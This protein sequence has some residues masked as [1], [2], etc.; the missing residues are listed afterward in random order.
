MKKS[1]S[2]IFIAS[3][4]LVSCGGKETIIKEVLVTT[5]QVATTDAPV[6]SPSNKYDEYLY[7]LREFSGQANAWN[8][9]DLIEIGTLVCDSFDGGSSLQEVLAIFAQNSDGS[10]DDELYA[11][12]IMS[13]VVNLCPEHKSYVESQI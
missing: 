3:A 2:F 10:Y 8:D 5:P 7:D 12:M 13:A 11:G 9:N 4:F 1:A 6:A